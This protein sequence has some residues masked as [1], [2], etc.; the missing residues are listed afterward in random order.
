MLGSVAVAVVALI[1][2]AAATVLAPR[3]R[4]AGPL[5]LVLVGAAASATP[6]VDGVE[7]DPELI[8]AVLLPPLLYGA[9]VSVP[10]MDFRREFRSI[11]GLS[12]VLVLVSS[13]LLG[14]LFAVLLPDAG[15]VWGVAL[16]AIVSPTD[17][18]AVS[19]IKRAPVP[20]R[21]V[22]ILEG[23]SLLNDAT[24]LVVLR[25]AVAAAAVGFSFW[26]AVG[27]FAYA[28]IAAVAI[29]Y[30]VGRVNLAVRRRIGDPTVATIVSF[31]VPFLASVPAEAIGSSGLVAAVVAGLYTGVR[32]PRVLPPQHRVSDAQNWASV[33][34]V[35]EGLVFLL[36]GLQLSSVL[37]A[38]HQEHTGVPVAVG[39]AFAA[40][41]AT[42]AIRAAYVAPLLWMQRRRTRRG[43]ALQPR[44]EEHHEHLEAGRLP[45]RWRELPR[46][47]GGD[48]VS[49]RRLDRLA[50]R[51]RR[52]LADIDYLV[53][54]PLGAREGT[55]VV[56][57]GMRGAVTV[58]AA[59]TLPTDTPHR[60]LLVFV[61]FAVAAISLLLQGGTV[62]WV[63]GRLFPPGVHDA[64]DAAARAEERERILALLDDAA[65]AVP[66][67]DGAPAKPHRLAVLRAQREALLDARDD[68][69]FDSDALD[70]AL[71]NLDAAEIAVTLR[72]GPDG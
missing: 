9:A 43:A 58:A 56:W 40:L 23:E 48:G 30:L 1:V 3:I 68:G 4:L 49:A 7:I 17:A 13:L 41:A 10:T 71:Q 54:R 70:T 20:S 65:E 51:V 14:A 69:A 53:S 38:V 63:V 59:Q 33:E 24:A 47:R 5:L 27:T 11:S 45:P 72:G 62:S 6:L 31:T 67:A 61:A 42:L 57:A 39:I 2:I 15:F 36:M 34:L 32:A 50:T 21:V 60:P 26:G 19:M 18:V 8:L 55:L 22:L 28:V 16:G 64:A 52:L 35:L 12:V 66:R 44:L 29:G 37:S 46:F 25:T